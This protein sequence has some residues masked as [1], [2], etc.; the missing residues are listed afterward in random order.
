MNKKYY[1]ITNYSRFPGEENERTRVEMS[2]RSSQKQGKVSSRTGRDHGVQPAVYRRYGIGVREV[3]ADG[4]SE[5]YLLQGC[6]L[7]LP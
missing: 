6:A 5:A 1:V 7:Q 3:P 4:G 2:G